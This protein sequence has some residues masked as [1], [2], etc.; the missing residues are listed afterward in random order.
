MNRLESR[1]QIPMFSMFDYKSMENRLAE[2]AAKGWEIKH[3]GAFL[4]EFKRAERLIRSFVFFTLKM[5]GL[6]RRS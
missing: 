4:W 6:I 1:Y 3:I 2:M 5:T